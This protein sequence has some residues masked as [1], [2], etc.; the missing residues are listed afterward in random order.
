MLFIQ[1]F[2]NALAGQKT[3]QTGG[4][5]AGKAQ[6]A[7]PVAVPL[8]KRPSALKKPKQGV[9]DV[10]PMSLVDPSVVQSG[11]QAG[12]PESQLNA[13]ARLLGKTNRMADQPAGSRAAPRANPKRRHK[14][15][16]GRHGCTK[17]V[18]RM[19][20]N[21]GKDLEALLDGADGGAGEAGLR[22]QSSGL[23]EVEGC[24]DRQ[25]FIHLRDHRGPDGDRLHAGEDGTWS[26]KFGDIK[27]RMGGASIETCPLPEFHSGH[28]G[29]GRHTRLS[30]GGSLSGSEG[31]G[32]LADA[33]PGLGLL[34]IIMSQE[35]L[36][37]PAP[38]YAAF[39]NR[40]MPEP[41]EQAASKLVDERWLA[42][43]QWKLRDQDNY[44]EVR[45]RVGQS[46]GKGDPLRSPLEDPKAAAPKKGGKTTKGG[47][48]DG[49]GNAPEGGD[50]QGS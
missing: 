4:Q 46:R 48:K 5:P 34:E 50:A 13:L 1:A 2:L 18:G 47:K 28:L 31:E 24:A 36:L 15:R 49:K 20:R 14:K 32:C 22:A 10:D 43:L 30:E 41:H 25:P 44:L 9:K 8:P 38:P 16:L 35:I 3:I 42:V 27:S 17:I 11:R 6:G 37:E 26:N 33:E 45:R 23:Q 12:I 39:H 40:R 7:R 19:S 21:L 29:P